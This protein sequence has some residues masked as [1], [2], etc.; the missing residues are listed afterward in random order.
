M[1]RLWIYQDISMARIILKSIEYL[2]VQCMDMSG[3]L[4]DQDSIKSIEC[5]YVQG[6]D[7]S[8]EGRRILS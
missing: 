6:V 1:S 8:G 7:M 3:Y 5:L 2:Y 4:Y